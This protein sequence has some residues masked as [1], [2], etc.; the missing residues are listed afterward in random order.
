MLYV[1]QSC[2]TGV[3]AISTVVATLC[4]SG[5]LDSDCWTV[6]YYYYYFPCEATTTRRSVRLES[7]YAYTY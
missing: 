4:E 6:H 5:R 7:A 3:I 1:V 2:P